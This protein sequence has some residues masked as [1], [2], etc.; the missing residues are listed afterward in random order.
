L[1][2]F[3]P[4][5]YR[6][7]PHTPLEYQVEI[8]KCYNDWILDWE[9]QQPGRFIPLACIPYWD[10]PSSVAEIERCASLGHR[11]FVMTG[12]PQLHG[13][14][15]LADHHWDDMWA[16]AEATGLS[17][18]F[19]AGT[20]TQPLEGLAERF[21]VEGVRA[22]AVRT[23]TSEFLRNGIVTMD[24]IMSGVLARFP[25]LKFVSVEA[26]A[27]WIPFVLQ[28]LD[29]HFNKYKVWLDR[30][31]FTELPSFYFRR[32]VYVNIWFEHLSEEQ[33]A[34]IGEDNVMFE[35]DYPHPTC[36]LAAEIE[37]F[38]KR[39]ADLSE[40]MQSKIRHENAA[41]LFQLNS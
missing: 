24:L 37:D 38:M 9:T 17:I 20:G 35:T 30:P 15:F 41:A 27:G 39:I 5:L 32:Q 25:G 31:E 40:P 4:D 26:G 12:T 22:G 13:E 16:A 28:G 33:I 29:F 36:M 10:I 18:S 14:P 3:G 1:G 11:G 2:L 21:A 6:M 23:M 7:L 8:V 19:H 34:Q